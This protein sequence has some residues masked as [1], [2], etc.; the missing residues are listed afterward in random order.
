M[1]DDDLSHAPN[2]ACNKNAESHAPSESPSESRPLPQAPVR[3]TRRPRPSL[4][5]SLAECFGLGTARPHATAASPAG[6]N[7][8]QT[9]YHALAEAQSRARTHIVVSRRQRGNPVLRYVRHI[10]YAFADFDFAD[11]LLGQHTCALFLSMRYHLLKPTYIYE[12]ARLLGR[13][14]F[15]TRVLLLLMDCP[16]GVEMGKGAGAGAAAQ[17]DPFI[18]LEKFA[19]YQELTLMVAW[20]E[21]EAATILENYRALEQK[22]ADALQGVPNAARGADAGGEAAR[23]PDALLTQAVAFLTAGK[24]V[25]KT[26]AVMLLQH[27][28]SLR[29][30][31]LAGEDEFAQ[32]AGI[33]PVKRAK[34][35]HL[36]HEPFRK[37]TNTTVGEAGT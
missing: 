26:D 29:Q 1:G 31:L 11:Y 35:Y 21:R 10:P 36:L 12:R 7:T 30:V 20:S 19:V 33:G 9:F 17:T 37:R 28:G 4:Q 8:T 25:N 5:P 27:F 24:A 34:L 15:R 22:P 14:S 23:E 3:A 16:E 6:T 13:R 2:E 32:V 18:T